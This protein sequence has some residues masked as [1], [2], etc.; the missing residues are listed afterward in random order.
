M[1][2][3]FSWTASLAVDGNN[4]QMNPETSQTCSATEPQT[5]LPW[6]YVDMGVLAVID[7]ILVYGRKGD[8]YKSTSCLN[9]FAQVI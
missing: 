5:E 2:K 1:L 4:D 9:V 6:W 8:H 3:G 7:S